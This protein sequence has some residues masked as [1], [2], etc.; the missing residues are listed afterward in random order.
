MAMEFHITDNSA[1]V[2]AAKNAA[3]MRAMEAVGIHLEGEAADEPENSPRRD[4]ERKQNRR[5]Q[6]LRLTSPCVF[7]DRLTQNRKSRRLDALM[8]WMFCRA[9]ARTFSLGTRSSSVSSISYPT[10]LVSSEA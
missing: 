10:F 3:V 7:R 5:G 8:F 4:R 9:M 1:A 2:I 6:P